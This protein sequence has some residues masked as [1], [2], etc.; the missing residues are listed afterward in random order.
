M[1]EGHWEGDKSRQ[2]EEG[3]ASN[4]HVWRLDRDT[5]ETQHAPPEQV[6]RLEVAMKE[7]STEAWEKLCDVD[8]AWQQYD[9]AAWVA[10]GRS[11]V[12]W[13]EVDILFERMQAHASEDIL[14]KARES[15]ANLWRESAI[16]QDNALSSKNSD[17]R[18]QGEK[19][20]AEYLYMET[21][22]RALDGYFGIKGPDTNRRPEIIEEPEIILD[23]DGKSEVVE[24]PDASGE[25]DSSIRAGGGNSGITEE[26]PIIKRSV[27]E[28]AQGADRQAQLLEKE[29]REDREAAKYARGEIERLQRDFEGEK[30]WLWNGNG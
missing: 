17:I 20:H 8:A 3:G 29:A 18:A 4:E 14:A 12:D 22:L 26:G 5:G 6:Q 25:T 7:K 28:E 2:P 27:D 30:G 15:A 1:G 11:R 9:G 13:G 19:A 10:I 16:E 24:K 23:T 21:R